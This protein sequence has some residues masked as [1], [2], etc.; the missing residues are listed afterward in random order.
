M[1]NQVSSDEIV[2][3]HSDHRMLRGRN[4]AL[5]HRLSMPIV[6]KV[7]SYRSESEGISRQS[8]RTL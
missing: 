6:N 1:M 5:F 3:L 8:K 7:I 4:H 2:P